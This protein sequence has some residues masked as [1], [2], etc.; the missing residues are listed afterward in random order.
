M[1]VDSEES[2]ASLDVSELSQLRK[3]MKV[4]NSFSIRKE[5]IYRV[6]LI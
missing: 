6:V 4:A 5:L 3:A 1:V 2:L